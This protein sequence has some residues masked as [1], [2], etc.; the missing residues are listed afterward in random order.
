MSIYAI[1]DLHLSF[2]PRIEKPM[3]IYGDLWKDHAEKLKIV[4]NQTILPEDT[5]IIAGDI[6]W[7][8]R[9]DEAIADLKWIHGLNGQKVLIKGNHE[10]WWNGVG[11]L[12]K[13]YDDI[14][15][16]QNTYYPV[17]ETAICGSRGWI[18]PGTDDFTSNDK[19]IYDRELLRLEMSL[20]G[21]K[22]AGYKDIIGALHY[23]P[24]NDKQQMSG[25]TELFLSYGVKN[26][27]YGHLH[28]KD[29]WGRGIKGVFNGTRYDLTSLD[30]LEGKPIKLR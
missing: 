5:V 3:E 17:G 14:Y 26:V 8:L 24:T 25:F 7:A 1:A 12:N 27:V 22:E 20:K 15:F 10:Y 11:R 28:G 29:I 16:L 21:A 19:K 2:D 6:S 4:W 30:Y 23:P 13:L 18:C 9:F